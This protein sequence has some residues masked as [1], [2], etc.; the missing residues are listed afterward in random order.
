MPETKKKIMLRAAVTRGLKDGSVDLENHIIKGYS[1]ISTG[2]LLGH[3]VEADDKTLDQVVDY[4]NTHKLGSKSRF[5]HPNM[6][7]TAFGTYLGRTKNYYKDG[8]RVRA[9]LHI[10]DTAF[11]SPKGNLGAYVEEMALKEPD[12]FGASIVVKADY[13]YRLNEDGTRQKDKAGNELLPLLRIQELVASDVV[14]EPATGDPM[15]EF[16]SDGVKPSAEVT[17]FLDEFLQQPDAM[18][19]FHSF[20]N[21]YVENSEFKKSIIESVEKLVT[22]AKPEEDKKETKLKITFDEEKK[23]PDEIKKVET[24]EEK[25]SMAQVQERE[26]FARAQEKERIDE[27]VTS[28]ETFGLKSEFAKKLIDGNIQLSEARK[29]IMDEYKLSLE[30]VSKIK[31]TSDNT[32]LQRNAMANAILLRCGIETDEAIRADVAKTQF[33]SM[34]LQ[35]LAKMCLHNDGVVNAMYMDGNELYKAL[36][37]HQYF[38]QAPTQTSGDFV[39]VLSNV[40]NKSVAKGWQGAPST[41]E[42]WIGTG[43]LKDFKQAD[44]VRLTE[45]GDVKEI[46]EGEA[47]EMA[48]MHDTK[49]TARLKTWGT[50]YILSRQ[51]MV[52]DDLSQLTTI[53]MKQARA[54]RRFINKRAYGLLYNNNGAGTSFLGPTMTEDSVTLFNAATHNNYAASGAAPSQGTLNTAFVAMANQTAL[55]PDN[56]DSAAI[57]LNI[58]PKFILIGANYQL[59]TFKLMNNYG[60][61]VTGEDSAALG[62]NAANIHGPGGPRNL[63]IVSD[64][65]L[66]N[67]DTSYYPWY[68][69]ADPMDVDTVTLWTLNGNTNPYTDAAP[70]PTGDARGMIWVIE[71]DFAF[72]IPDWRG[73]YC[74]KGASK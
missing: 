23:M 54:L 29:S 64:A 16:F 25:Y 26:E 67:I 39:N 45:M 37:G 9:D 70:T 30:S 15:F 57:R 68:L 47:P 42:R 46:H 43:S 4:G 2:E 48:K 11:N 6:S 53:P 8:D 7:N 36:V 20:I 40:L 69:A 72:S 14:D 71:H 62:S 60:Y 24:P 41:C 33:K 27:I 34:S 38:A 49:E 51:A 55:T 44:I 58:I 19:K 12:M 65:E 52:N 61:N 5:G 73:L 59:Q 18:E 21:R 28:C 56:N 63:V 50:K 22:M 31:I 3:G 74:N 35:N 1:V 32:D 10:S 17:E 66:D 13:E